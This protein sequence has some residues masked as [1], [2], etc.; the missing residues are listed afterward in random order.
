VE[1]VHHVGE[2]PLRAQG[3]EVRRGGT[4]GRVG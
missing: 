4:H 3:L 2:Y 1:L